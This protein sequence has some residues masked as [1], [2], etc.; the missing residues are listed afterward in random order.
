MA[1]ASLLRLNLYEE[2]GRDSQATEQTI[3]V[4]T[5]VALATG[6][7]VF[8]IGGSDPLRFVFGILSAIAGW[9]IWTFVAFIL[10]TGLLR[11]TD[12][13]VSLAHFVRATAFAQS[14]GA[15]RI[16]VLLP[17]IGWTVIFVVWCWQFAAMIVAVRQSLP[18]PSITRTVTVVTV[19]FLVKT[20]LI[21]S[22]I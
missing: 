12:T 13:P 20:L 19:G 9:A 15:L 2:V 1:R 16:L 11:T 7:G 14:P 21:R 22:P 8:A 3:R 6:I 18:G 10:G 4:L 5:L 17:L